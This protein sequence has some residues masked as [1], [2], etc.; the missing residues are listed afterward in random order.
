MFARIAR[1]NL[2]PLAASAR[3]S[4]VRP[5]L[6]IRSLITVTTTEPEEQSILVAQ[7]KN[8]P[9]SPHLDIYQPQLTWVLSG[10]HRITGVGLAFG[11]YAVTCSYA[12]GLVDTASLLGA[13][14]ALPV[15]IKVAFKALASFPF[16]F[17]AWNG[18]RHLVWDSG[19]EAN[20]KGVYTTGYIVLGL[21]ALS[22]LGL[23]II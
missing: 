10:L 23:M 20:K 14:S 13:F 5:S 9:C 6:H 12:F 3:C 16:A 2:S 11:F 7:R 18:V 8:R 21:S 22:F 17:H 15:A 4:I 1:A 19:H